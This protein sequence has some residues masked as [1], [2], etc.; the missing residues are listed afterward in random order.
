MSEEKERMVEVTIESA[1]YNSAKLILR[2]HKKSISFEVVDS[3]DNEPVLVDSAGV[4]SL[5]KALH[6][7]SLDPRG[8]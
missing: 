1:T 5:V 7:I 3:P 8:R 6:D 2:P 4:L